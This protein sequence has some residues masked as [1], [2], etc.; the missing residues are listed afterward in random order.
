MRY[1]P[2]YP[3]QRDLGGVGRSGP[4]ALGPRRLPVVGLKVGRKTGLRPNLDMALPDC[5][6]VSE[7]EI[8]SQARQVLLLGDGL[9]LQANRAAMKAVKS[10]FTEAGA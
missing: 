7:A 1:I 10:G 2:F 6:P 8:G 3:Y 4:L 9:C 5:A